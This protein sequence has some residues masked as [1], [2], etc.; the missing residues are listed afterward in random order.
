MADVTSRPT[1]ADAE[2]A[3]ALAVRAPSIHNTQPWRW[4]FT[5][6]TLDL[7]ADRSRR[8]AAVDPDGRGLL[9][10][11]GG[12]LY[13]ASLGLAELGWQVTLERLP[14]P[15]DPDLLGR[16]R[17][18]QRG[19]PEQAARDSAAAALRRHTERR[20]FRSEE[21]PA[22]LLDTLC[23]AGSAEGVYAHQITRPDERLDL[24]VVVAWAD[25]VEMADDAYRAELAR[26]VREDAAEAGEGI[27]ATAVPHVPAGQPR[28]TDLPVRDFEVGAGGGQEIPAGVD[29]Q[30]AYLVLFTEDDG[31]EAR[32]R[33][34][35]AYVRVSV[36][37]ERLGLAS[38]AVT[39]A[40]DL[41]GVRA[42]LRTLMNWS[43]HPQ[44]ILRVGWPPEGETELATP[45]RPV[46]AVLTV[47]GDSVEPG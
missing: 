19:L 15:Q 12:A 34:G 39:Q 2:H 4:V 30:P 11:C 17:I 9:V 37:A 47:V 13:L 29:E 36:E 6:D 32:L 8:L 33:A 3:V 10:S 25:R 5:G 1:R 41:P 31:P 44:M 46:A 7:Y 38:S 43:D 42:R 22:E 20:P 35:E 27:P 23:R 18:G 21:V 45:R 28:H 16:I 14:D 40:V 24:A 26:W